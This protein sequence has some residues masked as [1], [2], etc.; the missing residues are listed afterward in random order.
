[1]SNEEHHHAGHTAHSGH[2]EHVSPDANSHHAHAAHD[3]PAAPA[4]NVHAGH[5]LT[6]VVAPH[7]G[8]EELAAHADHTGHEQMFRSRFWVSLA[9]SIPVLIF[10]PMIQ[11]LLG[12]RLPSIP[13]SEWIPFAL[14]LVIFAYGRSLPEA[15]CPR[16]P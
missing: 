15:G 14:S 4:E 8:H 1:M 2:S 10:S 12:F 13:G 9:L 6:A 5:S 11:E 3:L 16:D 7:T